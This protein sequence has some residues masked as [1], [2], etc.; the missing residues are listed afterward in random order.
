[1]E[2]DESLEIHIAKKKVNIAHVIQY[3]SFENYLAFPYELTRPSPLDTQHVYTRRFFK[4]VRSISVRTHSEL[5]VPSAQLGLLWYGPF[6]FH[7]TPKRTELLLQAVMMTVRYLLGD[8]QGLGGTLRMLCC[9][10]EASCVFLSHGSV[11]KS[12]RHSVVSDSLGPCGLYAAHGILQARILE[13]VAFP[14]SGASSQPRD[15]TQV[16]CIAS[17]FFTIWATR[18]AQEVC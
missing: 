15:P 10:Y 3:C 9:S 16:S 12:E 8:K 18:E 7:T 2:K 11:W 5:Q 6:R 1:M 17:G 13:W 4:N 14:F